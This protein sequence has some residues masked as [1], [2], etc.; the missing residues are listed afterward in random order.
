MEAPSAKQ[1]PLAWTWAWAEAMGEQQKV[2]CM[3]VKVDH[4]GLA[5]PE[6]WTTTSWPFGCLRVCSV[7]RDPWAS[8]LWGGWRWGSP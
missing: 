2:A 6:V 8:V 7:S 1:G 3:V 4:L 5:L